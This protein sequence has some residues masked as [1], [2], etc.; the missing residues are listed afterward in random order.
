MSP[1]PRICY[2]ISLHP[3]SP[4]RKHNQTANMAANRDINDQ[5]ESQ[6]QPI[7]PPPYWEIE[8]P[9]PAY[10]ARRPSNEPPPY[11][12]YSRYYRQFAITNLEDEDE[13]Y[14][15]ISQSLAVEFGQNRRSPAAFR[16]LEKQAQRMGMKCLAVFLIFVLGA[17]VVGGMVSPL[18]Q[19][20]GSGNGGR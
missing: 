2:P 7:M 9:P 8:R 13:Q 1:W 14:M 16:R 10:S 20:I 3:S 19:Y 5:L 6:Q 4:L 17:A 15:T 12:R 18:G 11:T